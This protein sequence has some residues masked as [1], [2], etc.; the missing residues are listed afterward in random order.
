MGIFRLIILVFLSA[1][2]DLKYSPYVLDV[3]AS[4]SNSKNLKRILKKNQ[5]EGQSKFI[6]FKVAIISDTHDYYDGLEKQVRY[7]NKNHYSYDFVIVTGDMSNVGLVSEFEQTKSRLDRLKIPYLTTVGNH[8]L[9]IDGETVYGRMFG[10]DTYSFE[11]KNSKFILFNNNNWESS[12]NIPDL[13][14]VESELISNSQPFQI[15]LSH[16][17]PDDRDRFTKSQISEW[18]D[19][20]NRYGVNYYINGHNHNPGEGSFGKA[21]HIT[22]GSS[23]KEVLFE[24]KVTNN[25]LSHA[26]IHL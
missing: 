24:L 13:G 26:F 3:D 19:L 25:G 5:L 6:E 21:I 15:L 7:I 23:S 20:V 12:L 10:K 2:G 9:L 17:A 8:D 18:R 4:L 16:V 14:W 11:Y 1:C 22:A